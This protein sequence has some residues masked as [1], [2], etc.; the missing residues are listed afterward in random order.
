MTV[1]RPLPAVGMSL[2]ITDR[3]GSLGA[4]ARWVS[5]TH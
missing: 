4:A 3:T 2:P 1:E 5:T